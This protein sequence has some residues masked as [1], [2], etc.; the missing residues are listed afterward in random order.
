MKKTKR[1][2]LIII[3]ILIACICMIDR[4]GIFQKDETSTEVVSDYDN[5]QVHFLDVEQ[6]DSIYIEL[7]NGETMLIDAG[8]NQ[9][10]E[11]VSN[12]IAGRGVHK[13]DYLVGTHPHSDHIGGLD[14]V[15]E[16]F[17]I[18]TLYLPDVSHSTKA[19][20]DVIEVAE[21]KQVR[22]EKAKAG[23]S[24]LQADGLELSFLSPVSSSYKE[25]NDYSAV[26]SWVYGEN[27]FVFMGD[28][29]YT[30]ENELKDIISCYDVLKVG[31]HGS[32]TSSTANFLEKVNPTYAV[33]SCGADNSHGHPHE[34]VT[35]RLERFG[36]TLFRTDLQGT[37]TVTS[38]GT[39]LTFET[40][41]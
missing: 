5:L 29:E 1:N 17:D 11:R 34:Q 19:F 21:T 4:I 6:G 37:I 16:Q 36:C 2:S 41:R 24:V 13:I 31:H 27:A 28:A 20:L 14:T 33:I 26:V 23:V 8:E 9:M 12:F 7:P 22:T 25:I 32:N 39:D 30:V 35:K 3:V 40:E 15:I 18:G 10:G 38:N